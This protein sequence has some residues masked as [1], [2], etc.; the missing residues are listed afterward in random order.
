MVSKLYLKHKLS[1]LNSEVDNYTYNYTYDEIEKAYLKYIDLSQPIL[2][3]N[4]IKLFNI[5]LINLIKNKVAL[6][7]NFNIAP[8]E[9]DKMYYWEY[10]YFL[11]EVNNNIKAENERQEKEN[12]KYGNMNPNSM[13]RNASKYMPK[14]GNMNTNFPKFK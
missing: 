7:K 5:N 13:M 8:S 6:S 3:F 10:E 11:E 1:I 14:T 9:I 12:E 2:E 4:I